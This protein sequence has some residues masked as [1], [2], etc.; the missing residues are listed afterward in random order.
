MRSNARICAL[1]T[2]S[3]FP[4]VGFWV[5][6]YFAVLKPLQQQNEEKRLADLLSEGRAI[7]S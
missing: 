2:L 5:Y 6:R 1:V 4:V 3:V 7:K